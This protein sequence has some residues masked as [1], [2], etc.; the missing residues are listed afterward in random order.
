MSALPAVERRRMLVE[1][2]EAGVLPRAAFEVA[3]RARGDVRFL[4]RYTFLVETPL[5]ASTR[6]RVLEHILRDDRGTTRRIREYVAAVAP[7]P[8]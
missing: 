8:S 4:E 2:L 1:L 6:R 5:G 3:L 7:E